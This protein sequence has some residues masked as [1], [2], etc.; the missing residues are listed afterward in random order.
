MRSAH[1]RTNP[2]GRFQTNGQCFDEIRACGGFGLGQRKRCGDH[3]NAWM[4]EI[5][6]MRIIIIKRM[7]SAAA[8]GD[9]RP[10]PNTVALF[11]VPAV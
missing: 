10:E 8:A 9:A 1:P 3:R 2:A 11:L 6:E 5:P 4:S 7:A